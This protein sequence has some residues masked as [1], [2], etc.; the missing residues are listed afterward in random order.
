MTQVSIKKNTIYNIIKTISSIIF[1][2]ITFPYASRVL[3]PQ[4]IGKIN[5]GNSI[6]SYFSLIAT[7]GVTT[8]A[9]RECAKVKKDRQCLGKT[10]GQI[11]SINL[12]TTFFSYILLIILL[13]C[14]GAIRDY[15]LL[16]AIQSI[17]IICTT[18]GADWL[19]MA[20]E[21]FRYITVRT[22][23]FQVISLILMFIFVH[24]PEDYIN[25]AVITVMASSGA[26]IA[27]VFYRRRYCKTKI[28]IHCN[29]KRHLV[30]ILGLFAMLMAQQIFTM[31]DTTIIGLKLGDYEVGLYST[32]LKIYQFTNQIMGSVLW[33]VMPQLSVAFAENRIVEIQRILK[34]VLQ[35]SAVIGFPCAVGMFS[36]S[37]EM[38]VIVGGESYV[39]A[40]MALKILSLTLIA[41]LASNFT[42]NLN[43]LA[44]A[45]DKLCLGICLIAAVINIVTNLMLIPVFGINAAAG[46]TFV[47][48]MIITLITIPFLNKK[49]LSTEYLRMLKQPLVASVGLFAVIC[50]VK[51]F[52]SNVW[53]ISG[54]SIALGGVLYFSTL[55]FLKNE[56]IMSFIK[57]IV[58][59]IKK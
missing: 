57:D 11:L 12:I 16:I 13:A 51:F 5:F 55:I 4:N 9:I 37:S 42:F 32:A 10:A 8:Y 3:Q 29:F 58:D 41:G 40:S 53:I 35:F 33:V 54:V 48:Q 52:S 30:P 18:V 24:K 56:L 20:M 23:A 34:Y 1:P 38:I 6:V 27:N 36:L 47:S 39:G 26:N 31:C 49:V 43:L 44:A 22:V 59:M 17:T 50:V 21:D 25:Y 45:R 28:T 19:N 46:T 2:L 7:L 14:Y 15:R